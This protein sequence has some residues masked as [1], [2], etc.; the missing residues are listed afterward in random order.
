VMVDEVEV[1]ALHSVLH[2]AFDGRRAR[3]VA[4]SAGRKTA[5]YLLGHR[6]PR[7]AQGLLR[8][9]PATIASRLLANAIARNAW[10]FAGSGRVTVQ[11]GRPTIF[12]I[13]ACPI[14]R[15]IKALSPTCDYYAATFERLFSVLVDRRVK[16][17]EVDC[18]ATG[19]TA[20]R[21]SIDW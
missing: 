17:E 3:R 14:C 5:D 6:I 10:T 16:V 12:T 15:N 20:C 8:F 13:E 2:A 19:G 21:F 11:Y 4:Q 18:L 7:L 9:L 1:A